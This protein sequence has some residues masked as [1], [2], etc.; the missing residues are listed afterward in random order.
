MDTDTTGAAA[1]VPADATGEVRLAR[2]TDTALSVDGVLAAVAD[3]SAGASAVFVGMVRD[4]DG[5]REVARLSY[6]AHP[7]AARIIAGI[8]AEVA[9]LPHV[10]AVAAEHR[11]GELAIGDVAVV[12]AVSSAHRGEAFE[13]TRLLIDRVKHEVPIW[14]LQEFTDGSSEWVACADEPLLAPAE[15]SA[16]AAARST[17]S[18]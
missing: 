10:V 13:L 4:H 18:T 14:K 6:Q 8:A 3:L 2:V 16:Q 7:S 1:P 5:G 9:A 11:T 12:V 17:L 15:V